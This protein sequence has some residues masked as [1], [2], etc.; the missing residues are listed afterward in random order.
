MA[1]EQETY[2]CWYVRVAG[3]DAD[4]RRNGSHYRIQADADAAAKELRADDPLDPVD[5]GQLP[6]P[7][8]FV[9]CDGDCDELLRD[10]EYDWQLHLENRAEAEHYA[11]CYDR[12]VTADGAFC[13]DD[14]PAAELVVTEQIPGQLTLDDADARRT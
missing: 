9:R 11:A 5:V 10:G 3:A 4:D 2:R 12:I 1:I 13:E 7:C 14:V 6:E 8:W